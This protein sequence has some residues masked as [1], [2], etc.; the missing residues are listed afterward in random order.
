MSWFYSAKLT[1]INKDRT[2][3]FKEQQLRRRTYQFMRRQYV[4]LVDIIE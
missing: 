2:C 1:N 4:I 3:Q